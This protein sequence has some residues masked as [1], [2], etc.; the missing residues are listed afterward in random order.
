MSFRIGL[1]ARRGTCCS[2]RMS[3]NGRDL[4]VRARRK[5]RRSPA[6]RTIAAVK[7]SRFLA[8][9]QRASE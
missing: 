8:R 2:P 3:L 1:K 6:R 7:D 5:P 9:F 4:A